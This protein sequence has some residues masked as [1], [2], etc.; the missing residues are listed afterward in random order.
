[1]AADLA[2]IAALPWVHARR[3]RYRR[4]GRHLTG[5]ERRVLSGYF[6]ERL[7]EQVRVAEVDRIESPP[8]AALAARL[9]WRRYGLTGVGGMAFGDAVVLAHRPGASMSVLFHELVHVAQYR[10]LGVRGFLAAYI[11][12]W[13]ERGRDYSAI[14]L[15][16]QAFQLQERFE[17]GERF[18]VEPQIARLTVLRGSQSSR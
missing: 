15:E 8:L 7:L 1:M 5:E 16:G 9:G 6:A 2:A 18:A 14:P 13:L 12:G 4:R 3:A 10:S 11:R 17:A